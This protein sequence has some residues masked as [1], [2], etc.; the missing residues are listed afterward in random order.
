MVHIYFIQ[1]YEEYYGID[2][3]IINKT[4][5]SLTFKN[6]INEIKPLKTKNY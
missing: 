6:I 1:L 3:N 2:K 5:P 4:T